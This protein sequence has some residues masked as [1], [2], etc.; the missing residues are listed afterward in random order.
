[1]TMA[2]Y[3]ATDRSRKTSGFE[4]AGVNQ[5]QLRAELETAIGRDE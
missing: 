1:M 3:D 2:S 4:K 5:K